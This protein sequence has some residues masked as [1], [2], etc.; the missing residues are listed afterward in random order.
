MVEVKK[1]NGARYSLKLLLQESIEQCRN[2]MTDQ[3]SYILQWVLIVLSAPLKIVF[4][5]N[6]LFLG[7]I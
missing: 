7:T 1:D 2:G 5:R 4:A 3:F 6:N